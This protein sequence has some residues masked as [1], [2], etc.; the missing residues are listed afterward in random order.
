MNVPFKIY[1]CVQMI[2][3][4]RNKKVLNTLHIFRLG[5]MSA[6]TAFNTVVRHYLII[7]A[8]NTCVAQ[9]LII[10]TLRMMLRSSHLMSNMLWGVFL[11]GSLFN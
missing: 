6:E 7:Y 2:D 11:S 4:K 5:K 10:I 3:E 8:H 1:K 9:C